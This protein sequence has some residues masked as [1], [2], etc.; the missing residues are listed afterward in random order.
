[1]ADWTAHNS[2]ESDLADALA[3]GD[4]AKLYGLLA[5]AQ[6]AVPI[7]P[8]LQL[9]DHGP[10][11]VP[12]VVMSGADDRNWILVF[13]SIESMHEA[14]EGRLQQARVATLPE[15]AATWPDPRIGLAINPALP[16]GIDLNAANLARV[17]A[18]EMT[19][20]ERA[21]PGFLPMVQKSLR[22]ADKNQ[23]LQRGIGTVSG[24]VH[25]YQD[26]MHINAPLQMLEAT[27]DEPSEY[28]DERGSA[29]FLRWVDYGTALYAA[30][31]GG[32]DEQRRDA[33]AGTIIEREPYNGLGM[34]PNPAIVAREY[35]IRQVSLPLG[36]SIFEMSRDQTVTRRAIYN[37]DVQGW[38][39]VGPRPDTAASS[40]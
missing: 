4:D 32:L 20:Q 25:L 24:Y 19:V 37:A 7:D 10:H 34:G 6:Y 14:T 16:I 21:D 5:V 9:G 12:W 8:R 2:L 22:P 1:M 26:L 35:K 13:T 11:R 31:Y 17:V 28:I 29:Y 38:I 27:V 40:I 3:S 30:S 36:A 33:A 23:M 15:L 39:A 18:P